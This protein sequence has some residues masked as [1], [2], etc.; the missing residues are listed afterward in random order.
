VFSISAVAADENITFEQNDVLNETVTP[1]DIQELENQN[2]QSTVGNAV[3][4]NTVLNNDEPSNF[5]QIQDKIDNANEGDTIFLDGKTYFGDGDEIFVDKSITIIGGA[6]E[7]DTSLATLDAKG[8]S[9]IMNIVSDNVVIKGIT[10]MNGR[11]GYAGAI[12][13]DGD[14][15]SLSDSVFI[16]NTALM[17]GALEWDGDNG[18]MVNT[19]FYNNSAKMI[20]GAVYWEGD[21]SILDKNQFF[22]NH[23]NLYSGALFIVG[24][25]SILKNSHF[26][27]NRADLA[28]AVMIA[29]INL[30]CTEN[31]FINNSATYAGAIFSMGNITIEN[32]RFKKNSAK[33]GSVIWAF[34]GNQTFS[35]NVVES[36]DGSAAYVTEPAVLKYNNLDESQVIS[37]KI[38]IE[39]SNLLGKI[40]TNH[41]IEVHVHDTL[42]NEFSG[43]VSIY[44]NETEYEGYLVDGFET[45]EILLPEVPSIVDVEL[46]FILGQNFDLVVANITQVNDNTFNVTL[47][48]DST[49]NVSLTIGDNVFSGDVV[50]DTALIKIDTLPN[51]KYEGE[52]KYDNS[53][54]NLTVFVKNSLINAEVI[55]QDAVA[56]INRTI[57]L[58]VVILDDLKKPVNGAIVVCNCMDIGYS[59]S[60]VMSDGQAIFTLPAINSPQTLTFAIQMGYSEKEIKLMTVDVSQ[61]NNTLVVKLP[62]DASGNVTLSVGA[63][64]FKS[65]ISNGS[66]TIDFDSLKSGNYTGVLCFSEYSNAIDVPISVSHSVIVVENQVGFVGQSISLPITVLDDYNNPVDGAVVYCNCSDIG[67]YSSAVTT[68]GNAIFTIPAQDL[69]KS[70]TFVITQ[71]NS[72]KAVNVMTVDV[73]QVNNTLVVKLPSDASGNVTLSVGLDTFTANVSNASATLDFDSLKSGNYAGKLSFS[74]YSN[75]LDVPISV[76]HPVVDSVYKISQNTDINVPYSGKA[77]YRILLT[78]DGNAASGEYVTITFNGKSVKVKTDAQGYATLGIDTN[79]KVGTYAIK[80]LFNGV[81]VTN[82]VKINQII[83]A[84][85]KKVK[86]SAKVTK[87]KISLAKVDGKILSKKTLKI[88]FNKKT[89]K[90]KT[91]KKGV[92]TWKVKKSWSKSLKLAKR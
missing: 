91:N 24:E 66:A 11:E 38:I 6:N 25:N 77:S 57:P 61:V 68:S 2:S 12:L 30:T 82:K 47:P 88:K 90:V 10:F 67:Y 70:L 17:A 73:S 72:K 85:N 9:R 8:L 1:D 16:N 18:N 63:N 36:L 58:S 4:D 87:V 13:W 50:N 52:L 64:T 34:F 42:G 33:L 19:I 41:K 37:S 80:A 21:N 89:Y 5:S 54:L 40:N 28:G 69:P 71:G 51:G 43:Y 20:A 22:E 29:S 46:I 62:A 92:A 86:K 84:S 45:F 48:E 15:G 49:G 60:A 75:V 76:S 3:D 31:E 55:V 56:F 35:N 83:K 78:K 53:T 59:S 7:S 44:Y 32:N 27:S 23:A 14:D 26:N 81:S 39:V 74:E 65:D 79:L